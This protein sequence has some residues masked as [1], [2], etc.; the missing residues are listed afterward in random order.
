LILLWARARSEALPPPAEFRR[1]V[2]TRVR[3]IIVDRL[4]LLRGRYEAPLDLVERGLLPVE[5]AVNPTQEV[6][7]EAAEVFEAMASVLTARER[8]V[9][10]GFYLQGRL[11][12]SLRGITIFRPL[13]SGVGFMWCGSRS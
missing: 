6:E 2:S 9:F 5:A 4:R 1:W 12:L 8:A 3:S 11:S 7:V 10:E 13:P